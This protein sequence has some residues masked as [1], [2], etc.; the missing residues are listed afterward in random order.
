MSASPAG[1]PP[2][3]PHARPPSRPATAPPNRRPKM[4]E[5]EGGQRHS[6]LYRGIFR[7]MKFLD[8]TSVVREGE[9]A[10]ASEAGGVPEKFANLRDKILAGSI[11]T[12]PVKQQFLEVANKMYITQLDNYHRTSDRES[13]IAERIFGVNE[14]ENAIIPLSDIVDTRLLKRIQQ[15]EV[16]NDYLQSLVPSN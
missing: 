9:F 2:S 7:Y 14:V 4:Y 8:P 5:D 11:L 16:I 13:A 1:R 3:C 10:T 6:S 15:N 12:A